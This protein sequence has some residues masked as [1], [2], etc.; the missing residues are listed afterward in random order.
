M[1]Q[2]TLPERRLRV[3]HVALQMDTGGLERLLVEFARHTDRNRFDLHFLCLGKRGRVA[4]EIETCHWPVTAFDTPGGLRPALVLQLAAF[5]RHLRADVIH[6][7]NTKPL[8]YAAAAARLA[9]VPRV[10][11]TRHGQRLSEGR[12]PIAM[13]RMA[14]ALADRVVCVSDDCARLSVQQG[15]AVSKVFTVWNGVDLA[16]FSYHG[17]TPGGPAVMVGRL[18][19]EKDIGTLIRAAG[20]VLREDPSFRLEIAGDGAC[21][22][23]LEGVVDALGLRGCVRFLGE[24]RDVPG[25]LQR[26]SLFA[27]SSLTEGISL[28]LLEAMGCGLPV[29]TTRVGGN[30]EVVAE[31]ETGLLVPPASPEALASAILELRRHPERAAAMGTAGRRRVEAH[32][33]VRAMTGAYEDLYRGG[34]AP[35]R[36]ALLRRASLP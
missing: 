1:L 23:E 26:A 15:V 22:A 19:P 7:H 24:V 27:L 21:R 3:V 31:R 6:T 18:S 30:R 32:F 11:H 2:A 36:A 14:A 12:W 9:G 8:L 10:V 25:V 34:R 28:T 4:D 17:P 35:R 33:S 20:L 13:L 29:V 5:F 16:K